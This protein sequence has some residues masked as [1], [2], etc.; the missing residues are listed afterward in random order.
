M[1]KEGVFLRGVIFVGAVGAVVNDAD[2]F[3]DGVNP[4]G[5][6]DVGE[7]IGGGEGVLGKG[8]EDGGHFGEGGGFEAV[9][10]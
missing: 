3:D 9:G 2:G 8:F 10:H 7:K 4:G 5:A 6:E 1:I